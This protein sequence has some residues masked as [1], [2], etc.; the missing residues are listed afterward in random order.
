M[1]VSC[2]QEENEP[3]EEEEDDG[4]PAP[5]IPAPGQQKAPWPRQDTAVPMWDWPP[6]VS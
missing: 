3:E 2:G 4:A 6:A 5:F 1:K